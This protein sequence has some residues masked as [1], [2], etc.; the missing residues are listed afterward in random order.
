MKRR[1]FGT[2]GVRGP[3]GGPVIND[4]FARRLGAAAARHFQSRGVAAGAIVLLGR[5]PRQ[6]GPAL[7]AAVAAGLAAAGLV[8]VSLGIVPTP[9]VAR[10]VRQ[11]GAAFGVAITASHNPAG[12]QR[13]QVFRAGGCQ[14]DRRGRGTDRA[15]AENGGRSAGRV[16]EGRAAPDDGGGRPRLYFRRVPPRRPCPAPGENGPGAALAGWTIVLDTANGA[17]CVTGAAVLQRPRRHNRPPG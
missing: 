7:E 17:T 8:P 11:Q 16:H 5:D 9:A 13:H 3:Y 15:P 6:S 14:A 2:D 1:Y 12:R 4:A 10:A